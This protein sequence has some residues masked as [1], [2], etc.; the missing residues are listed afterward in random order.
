MMM[1]R[2]TIPAVLLVVGMGGI[3]GCVYKEEKER[4]ATTAPPSAVVVAQPGQRIYTYP[5]GRYE[6]HGNG[7]SASPYYW[8][9]IPAG[10]QAVPLPPLPPTPRS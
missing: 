4:V 8:V 10:S 2:L 3:S 1:K 5:E 7:T 9:W 6:L